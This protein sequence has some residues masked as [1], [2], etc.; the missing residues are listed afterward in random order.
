MAAGK[1]EIAVPCVHG[2]SRRG[3]RAMPGTGAQRIWNDKPE[4]ARSTI[5]DTSQRLMC[6]RR[7]LE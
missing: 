1:P 2:V 4:M 3:L 6:Q 7:L 5:A